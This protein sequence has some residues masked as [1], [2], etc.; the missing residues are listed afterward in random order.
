[1]N[2]S[3]VKLLFNRAYKAFFIAILVTNLVACGS[4]RSSESSSSNDSTSTPSLEKE[5]KD[6]LETGNRIT[7]TDLTSR[8]R[9]ILSGLDV[10]GRTDFVLDKNNILLVI[11]AGIDKVIAVDLIEGEQAIVND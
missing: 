11:G 2:H 8:D 5:S 3:A 9:T 7:F 10:S 1:M 6:N 4:S